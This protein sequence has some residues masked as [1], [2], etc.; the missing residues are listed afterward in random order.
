MNTEKKKGINVIDVII[1]IAVILVI[2]AAAFIFLRPSA[3]TAGT[4]SAGYI[5]FTIELPTVKDKFKDLIKV[6]DHVIET[7]AKNQLGE[8]VKVVYEPATIA[9]TDMENGGVMQMAPYP[10]HQRALITIRAPYTI[11]EYGECVA[12]DVVITVGAFLNFSTPDFIT[13]GFCIE[14]EILDE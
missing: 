5:D 2:A 12:A 14:F 1:I 7:V 4:S 13:S 11:S 8:V 6:G 9:S 10:N 3:S